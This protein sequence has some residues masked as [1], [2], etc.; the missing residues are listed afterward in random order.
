MGVP[1]QQFVHPSFAGQ[2]NPFMQTQPNP[3][4]RTQPVYGSGYQFVPPHMGQ[5][6]YMAP[7]TQN[8]QGFFQMQMQHQMLT[9]QSMLHQHQMENR[10][11][12]ERLEN[13][14]IEKQEQSLLDQK[15]QFEKAMET[16]TGQ[17]THPNSNPLFLGD[18]VGQ[19]DVG[20]IGQKQENLK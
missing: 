3:F 4:M 14:E 10:K 18:G 19:H 20:D 9:T 1:N 6:Q 8:N 11:L 13:M 16:L 2:P 7:Y 15:M 12:Q 17:L 5:Q